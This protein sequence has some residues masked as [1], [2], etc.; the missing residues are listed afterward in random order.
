MKMLLAISGLAIGLV[1]F[2]FLV[3]REESFGLFSAEDGDASFKY[4]MTFLATVLGVIIG[5]AYRGLR[6]LSD[7][8]IKELPKGWFASR[9]QSVDMWL[10]LIASPI[11]YA[12]L[13]RASDGMSLP[14]QIILALENGFCA[15]III[16]SFSKQKAE[17][18]AGPGATA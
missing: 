8:G 6:E 3:P 5:S 7:R 15:L 9:F 11:I 1:G 17:A 14:G 18:G 12:L 4:A 10:G 13:L 2:Q 16:D